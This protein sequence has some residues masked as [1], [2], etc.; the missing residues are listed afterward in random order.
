MQYYEFYL[1]CGVPSARESKYVAFPDNWDRV[2]IKCAF[3]EAIEEYAARHINLAC[4][5]DPADYR[6]EQDYLEK[7]DEAYN[8]WFYEVQVYSSIESSD[9]DEWKAN[10]GIE[11]A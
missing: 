10:N 8:D 11:I 7:Y 9:F 6:Y 2:D 1:S 4:V 5:P 3:G